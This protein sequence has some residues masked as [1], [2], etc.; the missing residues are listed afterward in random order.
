MPIVEKLWGIKHITKDNYLKA[1]QNS[2]D[3]NAQYNLYLNYNKVN[4]LNNADFD[5]EL[6]ILDINIQQLLQK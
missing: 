3:I 2:T 6:P 1:I 5:F 4:Q